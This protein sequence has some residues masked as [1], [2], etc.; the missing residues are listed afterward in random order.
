MAHEVVLRLLPG[1]R[2]D[3]LD[4][5]GPQRQLVVGHHQVEVQP[6]HAAEAPAGLAGAHGRVEAEH[7]WDGVGVA[8]VA[9]GAVQAGRELPLLDVAA[10]FRRYGIDGDA[11]GTPLERH[12]DRLDH[13]RTLGGGKAEAVGHHVEHP[14]RPGGRRHLALRLHAGEAAGRQPLLDLGLR[15]APR[16]LDREGDDQ[17]RV[18]RRGRARLQLGADGV[19]RVVPHGQR[20]LAVEELG[21]PREEQL[22]VVVELRHRADRGARAAHGVG[23]VDGD[24]GRH[25]FH[26]VDRGLVHAVEELA[27][28][29][30]EGLHIAALALRVERVEHQA[31]LAGPAGAGH[32]RQFTGAD[33]EIEVAEVVLASTADADG[34]LGHA[35]LVGA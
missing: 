22:Q 28:I 35:C 3:G 11:P 14:A 32:H 31:G 6:D 29:G 12:L 25:P 2:L 13:A 17:P 4:G 34:A 7:R 33:V 18:A 27:R 10:L 8:D 5:A 23:L 30:R 24:G 16:Q 15:R 21:S 19:G 1:G 20:G 26:L 9:L